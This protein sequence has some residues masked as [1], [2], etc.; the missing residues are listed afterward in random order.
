MDFIVEHEYKIGKENNREQIRD[1]KDYLDMFDCERT[2]KNYDWMSD[3]FFPEFLAQMLTQ[4]S[5]E[6][7]AMF[8]THDFVE[9]YIGST[10]PIKM[11]A[12]KATKRMI[13]R[14]LNRRKLHF[15]HKFM[16]SAAIKNL[17]GVAYFRC[18]W[19][20]KIKKVKTG[21]RTV[22]RDLPVDLEGNPV[23]SSNQTPQQT[24]VPED[25]FEDVVIEDHFNFDVMD[26]RDVFTDSSYTYSLQDKRWIIL[27]FEKTIDELRNDEVPM[28]YFNLDMLEENDRYVENKDVKGARSMHHGQDDK[29]QSQK[30]PLQ[31]FTILQRLGKHAVIVKETDEDGNPTVVTPGIGDDGKIKKNAEY[32]EMVITFAIKGAKKI[33]IGYNPLRT[34]DAE[35]NVYRPIARHLC[36]VHPTKDDGFG[37]GKASFE[38]QVAINDSL[39]MGADRTKL[40]TIPIMQGRSDDL[41]DNDSLVWEPG[42]FWE[43]ET[44]EV[45][46]EVRIN[47]DS[48]AT[49]NEIALY[50]NSMQQATGISL[51]TQGVLQ[52]AST[53]AT[54][55]ANQAARSNKRS[56][57]R[58]LTAEFTGLSELWWMINQMSAQFM[59]QETAMELLGEKL[60]PFFNPSLDYTYK[61]V[62][63]VLDSDSARQ[64]KINQWLQLYGYTINSQNSNAPQAINYI[65]ERLAELMGNEFESFA[66]R[67]FFNED[68][69]VQAGQA[70]RAQVRRGGG[71]PSNQFGIEQSGQE[72]QVRELTNAA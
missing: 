33:L 14:T 49:L 43:T 4:L 38:T 23:I 1:F 28:E 18:W 40:A 2:Q 3:I 69:P 21:S 25:V 54:A 45:L 7:E 30:S 12:A 68:E 13:N 11:R 10:D 59:R 65:L 5:D 8:K 51:E 66:N 47:N 70:G 27:R 50:R 39:N 9:T 61:P 6:A 55:T 58:V 63:A 24:F 67:F 56:N 32:H 64:T 62:S 41:T 53:S 57:F 71:Q 26:S 60:F 20:Q 31:P 29:Q 19:E 37:D 72:R 46:Q 22:R 34:I 16:R 36:Y 35:G 15:Y 44:G 52:A 42:A 17:V 48:I